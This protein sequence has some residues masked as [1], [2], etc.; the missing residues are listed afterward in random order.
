VAGLGARVAGRGGGRRAVRLASRHVRLAIV[1]SPPSTGHRSLPALFVGAVFFSTPLF[2]GLDVLY[3]I[4]LRIPFLDALPGA[5]AVYYATELA[6]AVA[7]A[8]RPR[9][10]AMIG[11]A[12]STLNIVLLVVSTGAAYLSVLESAGSPDVVMVNP[13]TP[14]KV[15]SLVLSASV[16]AASYMANGC[17]LR[18]AAFR[19]EASRGR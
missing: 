8:V 18:A 11:F 5:K 3:G 4:S 14:E 17:G 1:T 2:V 10:T 6:C 9:W 15:A 12:E 13:F 16:L 19:L 7:I